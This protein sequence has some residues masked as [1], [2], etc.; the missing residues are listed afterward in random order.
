MYANVR[1]IKG[2]RSNLIEHL[3]SEK[4][5]LFLLT[6][7]LLPRNS[8][9]ELDE[10]T[11]FCRARDNKKGRGIAILASQV[12]MPTPLRDQLI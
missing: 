4:P 5:H 7:T 1:G 8:N 3:N 12:I 9:I 2:K 6:E 11:S 10:Y